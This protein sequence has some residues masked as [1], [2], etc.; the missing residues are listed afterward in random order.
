MIGEHKVERIVEHLSPKRERSYT[1]Q[2]AIERIADQSELASLENR[3]GYLRYAGYV[4]K[5]KLA[6]PPQR[7]A[8]CEAFIPRTGESPIQLPMP[9]LA[10]I[11]AKEA[12]EKSERAQKAAKPWQPGVCN[13]GG[14]ASNLG[15]DTWHL[16]RLVA[17][18]HRCG[19]AHITGT[20]I[21]KGRPTGVVRASLGAMTTIANIDS[22]INFLHEEFI[23]GSSRPLTIS[24]NLQNIGLA[25]GVRNRSQQLYIEKPIQTF[26]SN[27]Q[28]DSPDSSN[29]ASYTTF[30]PSVTVDSTN[31][32][33]PSSASRLFAYQAFND[34]AVVMGKP[35]EVNRVEDEKKGFQKMFGKKGKV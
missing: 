34:S 23:F 24:R 30:S 19:A 7:A 4:V 22:L 17:N 2:P 15:Y 8:R 33:R 32:T 25:V 1:T 14:I 11:L 3:H 12:A 26:Y 10:E 18:G 13:P 6:L 16:K 20:E 21:V 31:S 9:N 29:G 5:V 27:G 28:E 35:K